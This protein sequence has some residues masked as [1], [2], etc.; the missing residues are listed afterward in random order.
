ML[1][2]F[3]SY[4]R[5][6]APGHAG[7]LYDRLVE[8]FGQDHVFRDLDTLEPGADF[9]ETIQETV[10]RCD[11][12]I[13][14]IGKDWLEPD[15]SARRID[16]ANDWVRLEIANALERHIRVIPVLVHGATM[17]APDDLPDNLRPLAR[18][19]GVVLS[20]AAWSA[21][22]TELL[23]ALARPLRTVK[24]APPAEVV[25]AV[26]VLAA[27]AAPE[28][29]LEP[30]ADPPPPVLP[31][32]APEPPA[33][34]EPEPAEARARYRRARLGLI[35]TGVIALAVLAWVLTTGSDP[36]PIALSAAQKDLLARI[37][38]TI[39]RD[40]RCRPYGKPLAPA[41]AALTCTA[42]GATIVYEQYPADWDAETSP[43]DVLDND[44]RGVGDHY[45]G[46]DLDP[47]CASAVVK[48]SDAGG[49]EWAL[50][51]LQCGVSSGRAAIVWSNRN[52][53]IFGILTRPDE[54]I[55]DAYKT[56]LTAR[57]VR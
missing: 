24:V 32:P 8:R 28:P 20:E 6:D 19:H 2:I 29:T 49:E 38:S 31:D 18:R 12:L 33:R 25:E 39:S 56:W 57:E 41:K 11:V 17:P 4:R 22:V 3:L 54:N 23:D 9:V 36:K 34:P 45:T 35:A 7:R 53:L 44:A 55:G 52:A 46:Y 15:R 50:G 21:Q 14:V 37:P 13:A 10:S 47:V 48:K 42:S 40:G 16:H 5:T 43:E 1:S 26:P 51:T 30:A 27:A